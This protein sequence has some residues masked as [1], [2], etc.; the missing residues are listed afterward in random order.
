MFF[1]IEVSVL[2]H[3]LQGDD[4]Q[5]IYTFQGADPSIFINLKGELDPQIKSRRVPRSYT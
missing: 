3:T 5:T 1:Y 4:D 2:V